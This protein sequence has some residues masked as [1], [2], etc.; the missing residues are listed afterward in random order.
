M[1][2]E[3]HQ[4]TSYSSTSH[5]ESKRPTPSDAVNS[6]QGNEKARKLSQPREKE[7]QVGGP[8]EI[9]GTERE[10]IIHKTID[11]PREEYLVSDW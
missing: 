2:D 1:R 11:K 3:S 10:S 9:S 4:E 7:V 6:E 5:Q 8:N